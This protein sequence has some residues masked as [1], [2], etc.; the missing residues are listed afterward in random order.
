MA[1]L[2]LLESDSPQHGGVLVTYPSGYQQQL[3]WRASPEEAARADPRAAGAELA[4]QALEGLMERGDLGREDADRTNWAS[5]A[6]GMGAIYRGWGE[7]GRTRI[8]EGGV[9]PRG[10]LAPPAT[11]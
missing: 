6:A 10:P 7:R 4:A 11:K 5:M 3:A 1:Q 9:P 2:H 8:A